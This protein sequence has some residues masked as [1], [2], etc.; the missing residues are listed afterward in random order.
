MREQQQRSQ[1]YSQWQNRLSLM[2]AQKRREIYMI[3]LHLKE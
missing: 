3:L 2:K 1:A